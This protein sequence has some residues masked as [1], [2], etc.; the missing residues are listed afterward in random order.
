MK[1]TQKRMSENQTVKGRTFQRILR[2]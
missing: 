1:L 2:R